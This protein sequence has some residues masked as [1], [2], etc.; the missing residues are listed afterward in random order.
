MPT[1][2]GNMYEAGND[3]SQYVILVEFSTTVFFPLSQNDTVTL[4]VFDQVEL[5]LDIG[6]EYSAQNIQ[7]KI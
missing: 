3:W 1:E 6:I 2:K 4:G 5:V 7:T